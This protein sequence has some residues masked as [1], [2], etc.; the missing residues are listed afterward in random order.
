MRLMILL[1]LAALVMACLALGGCRTALDPFYK[2]PAPLS[3][4]T[5]INTHNYNHNPQWPASAPVAVRS[6]GVVDMAPPAPVASTDPVTRWHEE[7]PGLASG[8]STDCVDGVCSVPATPAGYSD[9]LLGDES[10][11]RGF[12]PLTPVGNFGGLDP[13]TGEALPVNP[14]AAATPVP[15]AGLAV[16]LSI[17]AL[18][19][20]VG[21]YRLG[22][23]Q[24][25]RG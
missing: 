17:L 13:L 19:A 5:H 22:R 15:W 23:A 3:G 11:R 16:A 18:L 6:P 1:A 25:V 20:V 10:H 14:P 7:H 2:P 9:P 12:V 8:S 4:G 24:T 21:S